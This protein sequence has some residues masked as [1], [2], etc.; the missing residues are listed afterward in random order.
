VLSAATRAQK[1]DLILYSSNTQALG[2]LTTCTANGGTIVYLSCHS[3]AGGAGEDNIVKA[4]ARAANE[5]D[6]ALTVIGAPSATNLKSIAFP[7]KVGSPVKVEYL[8]CTPLQISS[9][10]VVDEQR[11]R[12]AR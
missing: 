11:E 7:A 5:T 3:G 1:E 2:E 4:T 9:A 10:P 6:S 8:N 12:G